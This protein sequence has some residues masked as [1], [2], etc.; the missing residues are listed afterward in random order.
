MFEIGVLE[1]YHLHKIAK[2]KLK[3]LAGLDLV[4]HF[5]KIIWN[6]SHALG[7]LSC[8]SLSIK[9]N[10]EVSILLLLRDVFKLC[11]V[12]LFSNRPTTSSPSSFDFF[13]FTVYGLNPYDDAFCS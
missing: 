1:F 2:V 7:L 12:D 4:V 8:S 10:S 5:Y 6:A 11:A 3:A 13:L 9:S